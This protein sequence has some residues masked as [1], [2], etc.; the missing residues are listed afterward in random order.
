[1]ITYRTRTRLSPDAIDQIAAGVTARMSGTSAPREPDD[2]FWHRKA[3]SE[4]LIEAFKGLII[5]NGGGVVALLAFLQA[6]WDKDYDLREI[7]LYGVGWMLLGL[8]VLPVSMLLR[9]HHSKLGE[10]HDKGEP[11]SRTVRLVLKVGYFGLL[12]VSVACFAAGAGWIVFRAAAI[13][14]PQAAAMHSATEKH[15]RHP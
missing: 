2:A 13:P 3:R 1:M 10:K 5:I 7:V 14:R 11:H 15:L 4:Q 9:F 8:V 6:I 12:Y